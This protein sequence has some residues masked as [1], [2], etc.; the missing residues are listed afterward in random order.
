MR[1]IYSS[2]HGGGKTLPMRRKS[3]L[4]NALNTSF[5]PHRTLSYDKPT[6]LNLMVKP[7]Y[8]NPVTTTNS[9]HLEKMSHYNDAYTIGKNGNPAYNN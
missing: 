8:L 2:N 7:N 9:S 6:S 1:K 4:K 5:S 3:S